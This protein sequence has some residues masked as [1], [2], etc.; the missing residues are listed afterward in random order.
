MI[1]KAGPLSEKTGMAAK[2]AQVMCVIFL[3][4]I[5]DGICRFIIAAKS[6]KF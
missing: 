2:V 3:N 5:T 1:K 4:D 6:L